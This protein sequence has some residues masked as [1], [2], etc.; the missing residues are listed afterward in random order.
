MHSISNSFSNK[1]LV[2]LTF[3]LI[4]FSSCSGPRNISD[5]R[6]LSE[7]GS[8]FYNKVSTRLLAHYY[9]WQG[10]MYKEGGMSKNGV[11]CSGFTVITYR[12]IFAL[13]L[14]RSTDSQEKMCHTVA[15]KN[16]LP[17]DLLFFDT[18]WFTK[19]VGI[20]LDSDMFIH[21]STS[22]GVAISSLKNNYWDDALYLAKR[23]YI[24]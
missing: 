17:G 18:G 10:T 19:H 11:D 12:K 14:P 7:E 4:A 16:L 8:L 9:E 6:L 2:L 15:V 24:H 5:S 22:K 13:Q 1:G 21:A 3:F 23:C 20:F